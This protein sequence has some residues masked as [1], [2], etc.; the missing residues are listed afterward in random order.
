MHQKAAKR[1][2]SYECG[3]S[4][5]GD[6]WVLTAAHCC[7]LKPGKKLGYHLVYFGAKRGAKDAKFVKEVTSRYVHIYPEWKDQSDGGY[8]A[9]YCLLKKRAA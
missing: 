6:Q 7:A 1:G 9:D 8:N 2:Q 4:I 5:I 3:G